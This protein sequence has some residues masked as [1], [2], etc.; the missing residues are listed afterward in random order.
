MRRD[1]HPEELRRLAESI[2]GNGFD[3]LLSL[4]FN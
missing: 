3:K 2:F 4:Y 1:T